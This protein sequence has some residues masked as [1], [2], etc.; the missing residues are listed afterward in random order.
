M[1]LFVNSLNKNVKKFLF[2]ILFFLNGCMS[3]LIAPG[4]YAAGADVAVKSKEL[5]TESKCEW[6]C[7][8]GEKK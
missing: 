6:R 4:F 2:I 8:K 1:N 5:I 3:P 7:Y